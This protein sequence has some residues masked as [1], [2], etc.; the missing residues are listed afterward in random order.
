MVHKSVNR[1]CFSCKISRYILAIIMRQIIIFSLAILSFFSCSD[2]A[3]ISDLSGDQYVRGR[4][5]LSDSFHY[6]VPG[7]P[8]A[9]KKI[10]L[11]YA[12][13]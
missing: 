9:K 10:T 6:Q 13:L 3:P 11:S 8:L 4:L 7:T 1:S 5:M 2:E 12:N